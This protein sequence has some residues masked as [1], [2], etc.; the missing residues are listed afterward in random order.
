MTVHIRFE[1]GRDDARWLTLGPFEWLQMTYNELRAEPDGEL[2]VAYYPV[3]GPDRDWTLCSNLAKALC[4]E[5]TDDM[6]WSD[7]VLFAGDS[8]GGRDPDGTV[9]VPTASGTATI[10]FWRD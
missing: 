4:L 8:H 7:F 5:G 2:R 10:N 3:K 6:R 1:R 9:E